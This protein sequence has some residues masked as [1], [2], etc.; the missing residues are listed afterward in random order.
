MVGV[1]FLSTSTLGQTYLYLHSYLCISKS[2]TWQ[3]IF[4]LFTRN[5]SGFIFGLWLPKW[6]LSSLR[7]VCLTFAHIS[8]GQLTGRVV[9]GPMPF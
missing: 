4:W 8:H 2:G 9:F 7:G 6:V 5:S 3:S 1:S